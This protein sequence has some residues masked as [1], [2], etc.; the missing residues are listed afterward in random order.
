LPE[1]RT[2]DLERRPW[3]HKASLEGKPQLARPDLLAHRE[4]GSR[5]PPQT[6]EQLRHMI[7]NYYGMIALIDHNVGRILA[8]LDEFG[9][10]ENT[11][12][13]YTAD[14]GD[15]LGDHGLLLKGPMM[16][17][18]LL[19]VGL[20]IKGPGVPQNKII[21]EPVS[22]LDLAATFYDYGGVDMGGPLHSRS[23]RQLIDGNGTRDFAYN[24]W[25]L[26]P[27]RTGVAL[28]LRCVRTRSAKLT[29]ELSS[30][31]GELYDLASD[32]NEMD[33]RFGD[34]ARRA[35]QRE[36]TEMI[37]SRPGDRVDPL[38]EPIGMA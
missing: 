25:Q 38:P 20:I 33:N 37:H 7:A 2:K 27:S 30:G 35:L 17:E 23:L 31:A 12:V 21:D 10:V 15:W 16:Y 11:L 13:V 6:D 4:K 22:T 19:R 26:H 34:P 8:A 32:P 1:H 5:V 3:W 24:E 36:L 14:H 28:D 9:L 29:L 18:G